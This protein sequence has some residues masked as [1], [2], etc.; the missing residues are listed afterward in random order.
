MFLHLKP[1]L[2]GLRGLK[3]NEPC[4]WNITGN[5]EVSQSESGTDDIN[6][7]W[8]ISSPKG[9]YY[10]TNTSI[11][12]GISEV[13]HICQH[14]QALTVRISLHNALS[15]HNITEDQESRSNSCQPILTGGTLRR[16]RRR[17]KH[18]WI[19]NG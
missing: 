19:I 17:S 9:Y 11:R 1:S 13:I 3:G 2:L 8:P 4:S 15:I 7:L 5:I 12:T 6:I 16:F 10:Q 14:C 18:F